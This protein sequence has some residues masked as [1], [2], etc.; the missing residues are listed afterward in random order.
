MDSDTSERSGGGETSSGG[1]LLYGNFQIM[2]IALL[3][4]ELIIPLALRHW[5]SAKKIAEKYKI[6][7]GNAMKLTKRKK[8]KKMKDKWTINSRQIKHIY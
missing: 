4:P 1:A 3:A 2:I 7:V 6:R 5:F 8:T